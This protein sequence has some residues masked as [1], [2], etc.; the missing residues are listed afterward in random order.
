MIATDGSQIKAPRKKFWEGV[1]GGGIGNSLGRV[2][3]GRR[4]HARGSQRIL[5]ESWVGKTNLAGSQIKADAIKV[6]FSLK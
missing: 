3:G 6:G 4:F 2:A 5:G 1:A